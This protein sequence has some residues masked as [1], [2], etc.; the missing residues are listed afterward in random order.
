VLRLAAAGRSN[1]E[2]PAEAF[3]S[4]KTASVHVSSIT[5]SAAPPAAAGPPWPP[6]SSAFFSA[7]GVVETGQ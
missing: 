3:I 6:T 7:R 1:C 5:A 2:I 4:A